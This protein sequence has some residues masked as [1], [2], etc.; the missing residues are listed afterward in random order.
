MSQRG[1]RERQIIG[2]VTRIVSARGG[3]GFV[4]ADDFVSDILLELLNV[5]GFS[6]DNAEIA[7][8]CRKKCAYMVLAQ[9]GR[10][11]I[12]SCEFKSENDDGSPI[13]ALQDVIAIKRANQELAFEA[14]Q[15]AALLAMLPDRHRMALEILAGGG[16][17]LDVAQDLNVKPWDAIVLIKEARQYIDR[18]GPMGEAA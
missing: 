11:E 18:V 6:W 17:P 1:D 2:L 8:L 3:A 16:T 5:G 14:M 15:A 7:S 4:V 9:L 13:N 10:R 12:S